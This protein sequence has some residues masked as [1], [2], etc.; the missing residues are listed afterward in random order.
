MWGSRSIDFPVVSSILGMV[1]LSVVCLP[2]GASASEEA[3]LLTGAR[4]LTFEGR[5]AGEG[6]FSADGRQMIFQSERDPSNPFYQIYLMNL[7]TGDVDA[8]SPGHGKTTC[9]WI[10]P[11][12]TRV[13]YASTHD[14]PQ[15]RAK[16][17]AELDFRASGQE[18]R[19]AWDYD[20]QFEIYQ[21]DLVSGE[22]TNLT[23]A[24]GYDAE[25]SYSPDGGRIAF[26]SNR[27]AYTGEMTAAEAAIFEHDKSFMMDI[28]IMNADGTEVRR[29]TDT[30]GYDGGPFFSPDGSH[31]TW[32]RFSE[33]GATAEIFTMD[34]TTGRE[35][36]LTR[37]GVMSW[38]PYYHP[39]GDYLI[40]ASNREGFGNFELFVVDAA[41][42]RD[43]VRVTFTEGFDGLPVF[44][45]DGSRLAW[46]SGRTADRQ[47]QIFLA[48]W[49]DSAAREL[50]GLDNAN[51][52]H[53]IQHAGA[54]LQETTSGITSEDA[55]IHVERLTADDMEGR[56]TGTRG[57]GLA[58]RYVAEAFEQIGLEPGGDEGDWFQSFP[59]T[60]GATL[61]PGN[62]LQISGLADAGRVLLDEHW[63]PLALSRNGEVEAAEVAFVGYGIVAPAAN[64]Q[65]EYD[66]YGELDVTGKWVM[67]FR[68]QPEDVSAELRRHLVR[69][70]NLA[71]KASWA[72]RKGAA[73]LIVVTGPTAA[74][75]TE[76]VELRMGPTTQTTSLA[77]VSIADGIGGQILAAADRDLAE[78]QKRLDDGSTVD[79]F[80]I[81]DV[82]VAAILEIEREQ[83]LGRNVIG[84]LRGED[85]DLP[86]VILGAHVDHLG[87]GEA[88]GSL[89]REEEQ[90]RI[91]PGADDNAS[92]VAGVIEAAQYLTDLKARG[93]LEARRDI[94]LVAWSGEEL[95][96]LGS[97]FF[98][99]QF[100]DADNLEGR[101]GAYLN[102]DMIG[103]LED[104]A[105]LQGTGSSSVWSREIERRN[106]PVG[107]SVTTSSDPYLPTDSTPFYMKRV[108]VLAAFTGVHEEYSTP[109][110]TLDLINYDGIRDITRLMAGITRSLAR[111]A[112][113]P[114]FVE[115]SRSD[116]GGR[117]VMRVYL[118]TIPAYGEEE[119]VVGVRLQGA[120][121]DSPAE[122]AG[123]LPGDVLVGLAGVDV[124]TIYDFM[125]A[126]SGL[127]AGESTEMIVERDSER[128]TL[129]V[130]PRSRD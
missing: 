87:R 104:K 34:L 8:L 75:R 52:A 81:P 16:M 95:G 66:S 13:M 82:S 96:T 86:P 50:L 60:A 27:R 33:D 123:I 54:N 17:Q 62:R 42:T 29:L 125:T 49:N 122:A 110:D 106:V 47:S 118:G 77:A 109:R 128:V 91:H 126:L 115:V 93:E 22:R 48:H 108:P 63:R 1:F 80:P 4:Q 76:L 107:L 6:Y 111:D 41:G 127:K 120:V 32:R 103:R 39:S 26:S 5:R 64:G 14:D 97:S 105:Y 40:Y 119:G 9:G 56:L 102:M 65:A 57:E 98:V 61:G 84:I 70:S 20:E 114:D 78:L 12:N 117:S 129:T 19:Y 45:P 51:A 72:K 67:M 21:Q 11:D 18:R 15:A 94:W 3:R 35:K 99:E 88:G 30:P 69:F 36:R 23:G 55:Q 92:G 31:L 112:E 43:P 74:A 7:E 53:A 58:T 89:A 44:S 46:T 24:L 116:Q 83:R 79:S 85:S 121:K 113:I 59:F 73:G 68:Y 130:V 28:Y 71:F 2:Q 25:G 100:A 124:E 38:A 90:G 37:T 10:H 101:I